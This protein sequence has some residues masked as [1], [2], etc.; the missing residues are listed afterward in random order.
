[1]KK[2]PNKKFDMLNPPPFIVRA[3]QAVHTD[4][5]D[6]T[7]FDQKLGH[8]AESGTVPG[9]KEW[10][11]DKEHRD[12]AFVPMVTVSLIPIFYPHR[13]SKT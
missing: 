10:L 1:M 8:L 11:A 12:I 7:E 5:D 4:A 6:G 13:V 3:A 2:N 9:L